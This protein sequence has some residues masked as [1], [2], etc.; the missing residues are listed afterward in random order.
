M[1]PA[2][3]LGAPGLRR[4]L[5]MCIVVGVVAGLGAAGF[6]T[7]LDAS[8]TWLL[9][10]MANY[11]PSRPGLEEA[12]FDTQAG[13]S[14]DMLRWVLLVLPIAGGLVAGWITFTFAPE[15]EGHGTDAAIEAYHFKDGAVRGRVP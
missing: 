15:A 2:R 14:G 7:L 3:P 11:H 10:G 5:L 13:Q 8:T 4:M 6:F 12:L 1:R 9:G